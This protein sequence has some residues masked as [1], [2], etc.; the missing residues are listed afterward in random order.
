MREA[1]KAYFNNRTPNNLTTTKSLEREFDKALKEEEGPT[2][3]QSEL[4]N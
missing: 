1:Q 4:F 2:E 3:V